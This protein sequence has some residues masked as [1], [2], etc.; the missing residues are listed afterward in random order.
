MDRERRREP[1]TPELLDDVK[2]ARVVSGLP[3]QAAQV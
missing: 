3:D 2:D 1:R